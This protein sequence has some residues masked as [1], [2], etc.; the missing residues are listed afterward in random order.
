M[1]YEPKPKDVMALR[2]KTGL[3][4]MECKKALIEATGNMEAAEDILRKK[5]KG[6]MDTR[7]ERPAGEGCV[8][9][10]I[11]TDGQSAAIVELRSETDFT[12]KNDQFQA[13]AEK[14]A[15]EALKVS[16]GDV[17]ANAAITAAVDS[18][19]IS[20]SENVSMARGRKLA[21]GAGTK[22]GQY[23]HHDKKLGVL[24]QVEGEV[25]ADALKMVC[26]HIAGN[27]I[28]P[29]GVT[30]QDVPKEAAEKERKFAIEQAMESGKPQEIAEKMV[31]GKMRKFFEERAL[32]EQPLVTDPS[33]TVKEFL[34]KGATVK[35]FVRWKVGI[36]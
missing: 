14:V 35:A 29:E 33:K 7:T 17:T 30:P 11:S 26:Q 9:I 1:S 3:P 10:A 23:V 22:F 2:N 20:T 24:L 27:P 12:A 15:Q 5:L 18:V 21:G 8:A 36:A 16:T 4:M 32:L 19:R 25:T 6:K 34:P 13:M 28:T 31:E